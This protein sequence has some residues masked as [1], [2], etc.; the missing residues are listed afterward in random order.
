MYSA[1]YNKRSIT[2]VEPKIDHDY[3]KGL[4]LIRYRIPKF[5]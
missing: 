3:A 2:M 4:I 5:Q 1:L